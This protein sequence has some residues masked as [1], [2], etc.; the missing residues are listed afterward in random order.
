VGLDCLRRPRDGSSRRRDRLVAT[1]TPLH[2]R[3]RR[4]RPARDPVARECEIGQSTPGMRRCTRSDA[5]RLVTCAA[6][7]RANGRQTRSCS[8]GGFSRKVQPGP[9]FGVPHLPGCPRRGVP[10]H[11][12]DVACA[13]WCSL[14]AAATPVFWSAPPPATPLAPHVRRTIGVVCGLPPSTTPG[15]N[16]AGT[17]PSSAG[18]IAPGVD[19]QLGR[20]LDGEPGGNPLFVG[21]IRR[22][23]A[24]QMAS[25]HDVSK[26]NAPRATSYR[27]AYGLSR[28]RSKR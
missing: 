23:W 10:V 26:F 19:A 18:R 24:L 27:S 20:L 25:A 4:N 1:A 28:C 21:R 3:R 5:A 11:A 8:L 15:L 14:H 7:G 9:A 17:G 22:E 13:R 2:G 16:F 6:R 12:A